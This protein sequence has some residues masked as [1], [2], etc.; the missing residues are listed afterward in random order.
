MSKRRAIVQAHRSLKTQY[1]FGRYRDCIVHDHAWV[2][3]LSRD[4]RLDETILSQ[5]YRSFADGLPLVAFFN[6][7]P[8]RH[9]PPGAPVLDKLPGEAVKST[10]SGDGTD[11]PPGASQSRLI[12]AR[13]RLNP[14]GGRSGPNSPASDRHLNAETQSHDNETPGSHLP[15][16]SQLYRA[17]K[18]YLAK[19]TD[20]HHRWHGVCSEAANAKQY[21][22]CNV[23]SSE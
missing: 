5:L 2:V 15:K 19:R 14:K 23:T 10:R 7:R 9:R 18:Q 16:I 11:T 4:G 20:R 21:A 22:L 13:Q 17:G 12:V 1:L 8:A 3:S 6:P